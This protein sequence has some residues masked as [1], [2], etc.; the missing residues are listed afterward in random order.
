MRCGVGGTER[1]VSVRAHVGLGRV[2]LTYDVS[3]YATNVYTTTALIPPQ[4]LLATLAQLPAHTTPPVQMRALRSGLLVLCTPAYSPNAFSRRLLTRLQGTDGGSE[5]AAEVWMSAA[6]VARAEGIT[7]VLA[8][9]MVEAVE[10][11]GGVCRDDLRAATNGG[12]SGVR[13]SLNPFPAYI[14]DGHTHQ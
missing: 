9:E 1:G 8:Q 14:W 12:G 4:T 10:E 13:W 11:E 2:S 7:V 3:T 6:D 5:S